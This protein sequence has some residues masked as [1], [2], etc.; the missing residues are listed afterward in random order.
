MKAV[1]FSILFL[2]IYGWIIAAGIDFISL[3]SL[4]GILYICLRNRIDK[5]VLVLL[6]VSIL[7][8]IYALF[9]ITASQSLEVEMLLRVTR[10]MITLLGGYAIV[11]FFKSKGIKIEEVLWWILM[12]LTIHSLLMIV[13]FLV[14]PVR[15]LIYS[16][17]GAYNIVN[18]TF[19][20]RTGLRITGLTYGLAQT[21]LVQSWGILLAIYFFL[22]KHKYSFSTW[23]ISISVP[24]NLLAI[25][26]SGRSGLVLLLVNVVIFLMFYV[27]FNFKNHLKIISNSLKFVVPIALLI[28]VFFAVNIQNEYMAYTQE[29][30]S[31]VFTL[32]TTGSSYTVAIVKDMYFLPEDNLT[33][34]FGSGI[35]DR[36]ILGIQTDVGY[37][38]VLF[39]SGILGSFLYMATFILG[40]IYILLSR[41]PNLLKVIFVLIFLSTIL[42]HGK[43]VSIFTRNQWSIQVILLSMTLLYKDKK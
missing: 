35:L 19:P 12:A 8:L 41:F 15:N 43:E 28:L 13:M 40:I 31:E 42:L 3:I 7:Y 9:I 1:Y 22:E 39:H 21:S 2:Y 27:L 30:V 17:T 36:G 37:V 6:F 18:L 29:H 34:I 16:I 4:G 10:W 23:I 5:N 24:L 11:L 14:E 33:S 26:L 20:F 32:L 25:L 38:R